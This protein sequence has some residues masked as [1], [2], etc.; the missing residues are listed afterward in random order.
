MLVGVMEV[1][2]ALY[3][4]GSLKAKRSVV[5]RLLGRARSG[6]N[7]AGAEVGDQ[8]S[9]GRATL[10]FVVVGSDRRYIEG[11]LQKLEQFI[12]RQALADV[13][14]APKTIEVY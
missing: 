8:D 1:H 9:V 10:G 14:E 3:D 6:F 13:L 5:K 4:N 2:L 7:T 12:E 11:Q